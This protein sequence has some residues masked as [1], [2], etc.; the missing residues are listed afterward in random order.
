MCVLN[1]YY[2]SHSR[3]RKSG[4]ISAS[5]TPADSHQHQS[6]VNRDKQ[7]DSLLLHLQCHYQRAINEMKWKIMIKETRQLAIHL[8]YS[9]CKSINERIRFKR[10]LLTGESRHTRFQ[11]FSVDFAVQ[12][13]WNM[14]CWSDRNSCHLQDLHVLLW[15]SSSVM[16]SSS[17]RCRT[18]GLKPAC[19]A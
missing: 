2:D 1:S 11:R 8:L 7:R 5:Q 9:A 19:A 3:R 18:E 16:L 10:K 6:S 4:N 15:L 13:S 17:W 14:C 12:L